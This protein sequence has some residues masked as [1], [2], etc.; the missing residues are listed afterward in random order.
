MGL[1]IYLGPN[2]VT[3]MSRKQPIVS[4]SSAEAE[5]RAI[6][7][8]TMELRWFCQLLRELGVSLPRPP[9]ILS[10][11]KSA[12]FMVNNLVV[13]ARTGHMEIDY[14]Y[15]REFVANKSLLVRYVPR[16][17]QTADIFTKALSTELFRRYRR[18]LNI[19]D[20][21]S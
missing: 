21:P 2:P 1:C 8:A 3:W 6:A 5:Y 18:R 10:N 12:L 20:I 7:Y 16:E 4:R 19:V 17:I 15:V 13:Q 11:S 14:L 9:A